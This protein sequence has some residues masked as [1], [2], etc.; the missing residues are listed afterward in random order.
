VLAAA[1]VNPVIVITYLYVEA[2]DSLR[3]EVSFFNS[4]VLLAKERF[5]S[6]CL[7]KLSIDD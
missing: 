2:V 4:T 6:Y 7:S 1:V 5:D 3:R